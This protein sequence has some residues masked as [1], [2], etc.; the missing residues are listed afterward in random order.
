MHIANDVTNVT[1]NSSKY[2]HTNKEGHS[3]E[4]KLLKVN[5]QKNQ[6]SGDRWIFFKSW[7]IVY[8]E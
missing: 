3:S 7:F 5:K 2:E 8:P 4:D 1:N 6:L